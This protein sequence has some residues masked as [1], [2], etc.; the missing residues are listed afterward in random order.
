M[1]AG[2]MMLV[3]ALEGQLD[4]VIESP[5]AN[6]LKD[7]SEDAKFEFCALTPYQ[8]ETVL[9]Q[10]PQKFDQF[11][12]VLIGGAAINPKLDSQLQELNCQVF[13][14]YS[15]TETLTHVALR[16]INGPKKG[17]V[18]QALN[19]VSFSRDARGC[20][21]VDDEILEIEGLITNDLVD[22]RDPK[23][24]VWIGRIDNVINTG[25]IKLD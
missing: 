14:S 15:M 12:M 5:K 11:K 1:V 8:A 17:K 7:I 23:S 21:I 16:R 4:L 10:S 25:G 22:L 13:H 2:M 3:R 24:F 6:P 20:L 19:G 9:H 18:Y